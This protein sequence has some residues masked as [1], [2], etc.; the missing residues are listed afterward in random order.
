MTAA[1]SGACQRIRETAK[2]SGIESMPVQSQLPT[3][4]PVKLTWGLPSPRLTSTLIR[5]RSPPYSASFAP[6]AQGT[7]QCSRA[8]AVLCPVLMQPQRRGAS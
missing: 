7:A 8:L 6:G 2:G 1:L 3:R 4:K 5:Q